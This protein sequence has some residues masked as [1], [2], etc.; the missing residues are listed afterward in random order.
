MGKNKPGQEGAAIYGVAC[1]GR[2]LSRDWKE[3][4]VGSMQPPGRRM[5]HRRNR[6]AQLLWAAEN[7]TAGLKLGRP[8]FDRGGSSYDTDHKRLYMQRRGTG[9]HYSVHR[10]S[11]AGR[12]QLAVGQGPCTEQRTPGGGGLGKAIN[13]RYCTRAR[14][15]IQVFAISKMNLT[16]AGPHYSQSVNSP[17]C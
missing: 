14:H 13:T 6:V 11:D 9:H 3:V 15:V 2:D 17:T 1:P 5:L 12:L 7:S 4:R 10:E 16:T 8:D